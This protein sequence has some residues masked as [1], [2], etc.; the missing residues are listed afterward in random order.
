MFNL[1]NFYDI[2]YAINLRIQKFPILDFFFPRTFSFLRKNF[3]LLIIKEKH[4]RIYLK[5]TLHTFFSIPLCVCV[6][7]KL[8]SKAFASTSKNI[9][10]YFLFL[11][12]KTKEMKC[13]GKNGELIPLSSSQKAIISH[14]KSEIAKKK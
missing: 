14:I 10:P 8:N 1:Q 11:D 7:V 9:S 3:S 13:F 12:Q 5:M 2:F 4:E 6:C